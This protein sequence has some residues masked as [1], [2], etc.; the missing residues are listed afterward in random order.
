MGHFTT[1][2]SRRNASWEHV[3]FIMDVVGVQSV[4]E[5]VYKLSMKD[6]NGDVIYCGLEALVTASSYF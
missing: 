1:T 2:S 3:C 6:G 5:L 4:R